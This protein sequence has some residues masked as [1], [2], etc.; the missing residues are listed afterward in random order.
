[1]AEMA[2]QIVAQLKQKYFDE[3]A[4]PS[5]GRHKRFYA[6]RVRR[7]R[8]SPPIMNGKVRHAIP[9]NQLPLHLSGVGYAR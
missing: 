7:W 2:S 8:R 3:A 9:L 1:M 6:R 5:A 4:K